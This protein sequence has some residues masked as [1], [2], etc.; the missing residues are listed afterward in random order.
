MVRIASTKRK[1]MR[2]RKYLHHIASFSRSEISLKLYWSPL[3]TGQDLICFDVYMTERSTP[4]NTWLLG[5]CSQS[6]KWR[7]PGTYT[8][9]CCLSKGVHT[10]TCK[11]SRAKNDWSNN[12]VMFMGHRFCEDFVGY[13]AVFSINISGVFIDG[14]IWILISVLST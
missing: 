3:L 7:G 8:E 14:K 9:S 6:Q 2:V 13:E 5:N 1:N 12:V 4:D 11:T 10:L